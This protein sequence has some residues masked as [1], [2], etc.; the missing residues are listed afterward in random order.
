M[1]TFTYTVHF[2]LITGITNSED[3]Q[4]RLHPN[5]ATND[6]SVR[7]LSQNAEVT[8]C[9]P[10]G[11]IIRQFFIEENGQFSIRDLSVGFYF[12]QIMTNA[13]E[14]KTFRLVKID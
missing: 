2:N 9:K 1:T 14:V 8:I 11:Q 4:L 12:V 3:I 5:P 13:S 7:G 10:N 6:V